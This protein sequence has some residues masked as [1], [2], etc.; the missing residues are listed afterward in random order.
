MVCGRREKGGERKKVRRKRERNGEKERYGEV[1]VSL[2]MVSD[3]GKQELYGVMDRQRHGREIG[4][5]DG[6]RR[7]VSHMK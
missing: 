3:E 4:W 6:S 2:R 7:K 1:E 5:E